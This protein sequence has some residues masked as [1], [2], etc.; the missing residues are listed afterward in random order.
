MLC[1]HFSYLKRKKERGYLLPQTRTIF[2]LTHLARNERICGQEDRDLAMISQGK[3]LQGVSMGHHQCEKCCW[4]FANVGSASW[5]NTPLLPRCLRKPRTL[6][7]LLSN[8]YFCW[9]NDCR[10]PQLCMNSLSQSCLWPWVKGLSY[11]MCFGSPNV[12]SLLICSLRIWW[13]KSKL[14]P[15][16]KC[17]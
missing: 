1:L 8:E 16:K 3:I 6:G 5:P 2:A 11:F 7:S 14:S 13:K 15:G 4:W 10:V 12:C 17:T 9:R